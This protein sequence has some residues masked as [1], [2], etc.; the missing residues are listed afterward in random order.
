MSGKVE[1]KGNGIGF[2]GLL[3][4]LFIGLKLTGYVTWSWFWVL[5][6]LIFSFGLAILFLVVAFILYMVSQSKGW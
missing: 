4:V 2:F 6:P 5:S 3:T 1:I